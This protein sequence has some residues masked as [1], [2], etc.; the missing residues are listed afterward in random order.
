M[1]WLDITDC[2][3]SS[4]P[5]REGIYSLRSTGWTS[6]VTGRLLS[7]TGHVH[8]GGIETI[9]L[10]NGE[11]IC[12]SVQIYG[13]KPGFTTPG[14]EH[15][16]GHGDG[17]GDGTVAHI[18]GAGVCTDFGTVEVGDELV[19]VANYN[20]TA[21]PLDVGHDGEPH[22]VM[23]ISRVSLSFFFFLSLSSQYCRPGVC[24]Y[25]FR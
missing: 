1:A 18:S 15:D 21:H 12:T 24:L 25:A 9:I 13:G 19:V 22:P 14:G 16:H 8:D 2:G 17:D 10:K 6:T 4:V 11:P 5:A 3:I 7:A 20:T 23:G